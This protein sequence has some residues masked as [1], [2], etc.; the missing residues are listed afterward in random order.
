MVD[1]EEQVLI[2][3]IKSNQHC[4]I[5]LV[6]PDRRGDLSGRWN[7]R[8]HQSTQSQI[9]SQQ[10]QNTSAGPDA[11]AVHPVANFAWKHSLVNI[12]SAMMVDILHQL[13]KGIVKRLLDWTGDLVNN[14]GVGGGKRK[15]GG[16][17]VKDSSYA[18]QLDE[19]F[20]QV[21]PFHNLK[22]FTNFSKVQQWTGNEQKALVQQLVPVLAP[23]LTTQAPAALQCI[24]AV[25][26][27]VVLA[28]Y[29]SHDEHTLGYMAASLDRLDKLKKVFQHSRPT[30]KATGEHHFNIPKL[31]VMTH[32]VDF[33]RLYGSAQGYDTCY[34]E[35]AH[36]FLVKDF[37]SRTNKNRGFEEQ[38]LHHN[39]RRNNMAAMADVLLFT[40][41]NPRTQVD[42][43]SQIQVTK[44]TRDPIDLSGLGI[45]CSAADSGGPEE[46]GL[47]ASCWKKARDVSQAVK[48]PDF[49]DALAVFVRESRIKHDG[50]VHAQPAAAFD[51]DRREA[52]PTW[53]GN[54]YISLHSSISCWERD[55]KD[56]RATEQ[57]V[58]RHAVCSPEWRGEKKNWRRDFV[59]VQEFGPGEGAHAT[60]RPEVLDG[61]LL[62]QLQLIVTVFDPTRQGARGKAARHTGALVELF[63]WRRGGLVHETHGMFEVAR[64]C[65]RAS[66][67]PRALGAMR[68]YEIPTIIHCAHLVPKDAGNSVYYVN[69]WIN[70]EAYNTIYDPDF[71]AKNRRAAAKLARTLS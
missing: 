46:L 23:M 68:F 57:L 35:A 31:H 26:D 44:P 54:Y 2:T 40:Q 27:F 69:N 59:W 25:M 24:R 51:A 53:V 10:R 70:W 14:L 61:R 5:C 60:N 7:L 42:V 37:F 67:N 56:S 45:L 16:K 6:P 33:I 49:L 4:S 47:K 63:E 32:Y 20:R 58:Q 34:S 71:L 50:S 15:R 55:G 36:K 43:D 66:K 64:Q 38:I 29:A 8:T 65:P 30:S 1:Y 17:L 41:T 13:L 62:G 18:I 52:D 39:T 21:P 3:G 28:S 19:R 12:H 22:R 11:M 9:V 48:I